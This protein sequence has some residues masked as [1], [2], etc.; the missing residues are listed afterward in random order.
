MNTKNSAGAVA[1]EILAGERSD[2]ER[3]AALLEVLVSGFVFAI[4][5]IGLALLL[6]LG[7]T[8]VLA[9]GDERI[10]LYLAQ[11]RIDELRT[12]G[13]DALV[14]GALPAVEAAGTI[15]GL[16]Q[17]SRETLVELETASNQL[18]NDGLPPPRRITV[19]VRATVRQ[20]DPVT[21]RTVVF[22]H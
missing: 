14:P 3:G 10:A 5:L 4:A 18:D 8:F 13:F 21:V 19:T 7:K 22:H 12:N 16:P 6:S 2:R 11:Q 1:D 20:V 9:E 15:S 17:F